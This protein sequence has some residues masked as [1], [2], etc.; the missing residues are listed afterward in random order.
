M[1]DL[2]G[3]SITRY[4]S[5]GDKSDDA[6]KFPE[7][8]DPLNH[9]MRSQSSSRGRKR[10]SA[11]TLDTGPATDTTNTRT[12]ESSGPYSRNFQQKL[13][14]GGIYPDKYE[15]PDGRVPPKPDNLE[16]IN[17][18]LAQSRPSLS[19]S[20]FSYDKFEEFKRADAHVSK[21]NKQQNG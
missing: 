19:P 18:R 5:V 6:F 10:G 3:V 14:D 13:I 8:V 7:P 17:Q 16:E 9:S 11:S 2:K 15:Y 1:S 21:E 20:N 4:S 12:T